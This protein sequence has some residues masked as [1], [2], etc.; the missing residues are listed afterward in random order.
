MDQVPQA[1]VRY[2]R[3]GVR[4][5]AAGMLVASFAVVASVITH[6]PWRNGSASPPPVAPHKSQPGLWGAKQAGYRRIDAP[7]ATALR[8]LPVRVVLPGAAG[9][10]AGVYAAAHSIRVRYASGS[11]FGVYLLTVW[12]SRYGVGPRAIRTRASTCRACT[13]NRLI[14][15]GSGVPAAVAAGG[16]HPST[17]TWREGGRTFEIRGPG[18]T[19]SNRDAVAA[20][21]AVARANA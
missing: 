20:A 18:A 12:G 2:Y 10:P 5:L 1:R 6:L 17:V 7:V 21:R 19:F 4:V 14:T 13:H 9:K 3:L 11:H 8:Q 16:G 15:L